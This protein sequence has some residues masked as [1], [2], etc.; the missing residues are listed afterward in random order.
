M[1][2]WRYVEDG[3]AL[4]EESG[5][6]LAE[7]ADFVTE[8]WTKPDASIWELGDYRQY[9]Q[10]KLAAWLALDRAVRLAEHGELPAE[11]V[12]RWR[13]AAAAARHYV[14]HD[15]WSVERSAYVREPGSTALD[16]S[17]L[18]A[19][20]EA[21][22]FVAGDDPRLVATIDAIRAELGRGPLIYRY[23]G[24]E[25]KE[26]AFLVCSFWLAEALARAGRVEAAEELMDAMVGLANDVGLYSEQIDPDSLD[27]LGNFPQAL[28]HLALVN[29]AFVV[30]D[31]ARS[32]RP[33]R[34]ASRPAYG[35]VGP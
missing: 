31:A 24:M 2:A 3:N 6:R 32:R 5:A 28:S 8:T 1:T 18:L 15:C 16:A 34:A 10:G 21:V 4:D 14:E 7:L 23:S 9:T 33:R 35:P 25:E 20:R 29:A 11:G 13:T 26:G 30:R 19:C 22:D 12:R 27:M 17:V